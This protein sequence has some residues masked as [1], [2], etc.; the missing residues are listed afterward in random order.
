MQYLYHGFP[1]PQL[2]G[3]QPIM[4]P[5]LSRTGHAD[6]SDQGMEYRRTINLQKS[7][8]QVGA[9]PQPTQHLGGKILL[10]NS[11]SVND[12]RGESGGSTYML[13]IKVS[14]SGQSNRLATTPLQAPHPPYFHPGTGVWPSWRGS[15][16]LS[17]FANPTSNMAGLG[18]VSPTDYNSPH[19]SYVKTLSKA[20]ENEVTTHEGSKK[21]L[22]RRVQRERNN[23]FKAKSQN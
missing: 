8:S 23:A 14:G 20:G 7:G 17:L 16:V 9:G 1:H 4:P 15:S 18:S 5:L 6:L 21:T 2:S 22:Q 13:H 3:Q 11:F 12:N 19:N 10:P